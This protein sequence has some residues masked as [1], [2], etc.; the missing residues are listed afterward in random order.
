MTDLRKNLSR[1]QHVRAD[2]EEKVGVMATKIDQIT[3][4][5]LVRKRLIDELSKEKTTLE[6][7]LRDRDEEIKGKTR[8]V[9]V[10]NG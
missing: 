7:K 5:L 2:L 4:D 9:E 3:A 1:T 6:W 8:L 10:N